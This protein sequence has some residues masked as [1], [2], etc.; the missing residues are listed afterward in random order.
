MDDPHDFH[1]Q[2]GGCHCR[3]RGWP[4]WLLWG[5][6]LASGISRQPLGQ[7]RSIVVVVLLIQIPTAH[8]EYRA[9]PG[10]RSCSDAPLPCSGAT[11]QR[12]GAAAHSSLRTHIA[13]TLQQQVPVNQN[14]D[15]ILIYG[16]LLS[17]FEA[18]WEE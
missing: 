18:G 8:S 5:P 6:K 16:W 9:H 2:H 13:P 11:Q 4:K 12:S 10:K 7:D 15:L 14:A 17:L 1:G 3:L